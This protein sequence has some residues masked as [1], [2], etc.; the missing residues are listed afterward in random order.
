MIDRIKNSNKLSM[1]EDPCGDFHAG[2]CPFCKPIRFNAELYIPS[3]LINCDKK[4]YTCINKYCLKKGTLEELLE[5]I[6]KEA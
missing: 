3:L 2:I 4:T 5:E 6:D 1:S